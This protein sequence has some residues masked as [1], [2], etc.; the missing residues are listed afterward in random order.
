MITRGSTMARLRT[1]IATERPYMDPEPWL[2]VLA[3]RIGADGRLRRVNGQII[4]PEEAVS[5]VCRAADTQ[6]QAPRPPEATTIPTG[7]QIDL[8]ALRRGLVALR[9]REAEQPR[10]IT[11]VM[12]RLVNPLDTITP[13]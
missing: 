4:T 10:S 3:N 7:D 5:L 13:G 11:D 6:A 8:V 12:N 2:V 1:L 9:E